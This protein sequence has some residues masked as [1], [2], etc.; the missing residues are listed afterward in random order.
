MKPVREGIKVAVT[1]CPRR[2]RVN[3]DVEACPAKVVVEVA[4]QA[5]CAADQ[6]PMHF[7]KAPIWTRQLL[8]SKNGA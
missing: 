3:T 4:Q 2:T 6:H 7:G 5:P 8:Q 1:A